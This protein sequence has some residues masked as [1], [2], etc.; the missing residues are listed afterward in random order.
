MKHNFEYFCKEPENIE[1]YEKAAADNFKGWICHHRKG[2]D[3]PREELKALGQYYNVSANELIFLKRSEHQFLHQKG[4]HFSE[5]T[6]N[7]ISEAQKGKPSPN[8][9]KHPSEETKKKLSLQKTGRHWFNNGKENR[10]CFECPP[11]F[12]IGMF[13]RK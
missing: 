3:I 9:G 6:K 1:N 2:I 5:K 4:K 10:F 8:K 12:V 7:K 11:G 13:K